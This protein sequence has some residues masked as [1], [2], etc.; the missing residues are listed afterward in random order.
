[1]S[2]VIVARFR[3]A[4]LL[5]VAIL[6]QVTLA[7]DI[8][9][10]GVAPDLMLLF[11]ICAGLAGGAELGGTV[12]FAAGL[13]TDLFLQTTP[14]GLSALAYCLVGFAV[15]LLR[16]GVLRESRLLPPIVA[17]VASAAGVV[18]FVLIGVMVGQSQLSE[19]GPKRI[20]ETAVIVALMN[21]VLAFPV[22]RIVGWAASGS[23]SAGAR[24]DNTALLK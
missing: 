2:P 15:G 13:L 17:T 3:L 4:A 5:L 20:V 16:R 23:A 11:A 19:L 24:V 8:R 7:S 22:S 6:I 10:R 1:V 21:T 14:L 9:I 12:G 18:L